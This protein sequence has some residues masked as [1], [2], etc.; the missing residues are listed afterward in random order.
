MSQL[1]THAFAGG[2][3]GSYVLT[4][5]WS[6]YYSAVSQD[7]KSS[8]LKSA[9]VVLGMTWTLY[10]SEV[11]HADQTPIVLMIHMHRNVTF[12]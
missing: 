6:P 4:W 2:I 10:V 12:L 5:L 9:S 1:F 7:H 3:I 8:T 11:D